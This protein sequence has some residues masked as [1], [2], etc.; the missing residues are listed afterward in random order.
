MFSTWIPIAELEAAVIIELWPLASTTTLARTSSVDAV[1]G[2][3]LHADGPLAVEQHVEHARPF[4]DLD[5]VLA[6]VVQHHLV[7]LA[8]EHLPGLRAFVR[9]V[10]VE[11][12]RLGQ[13]AA[14]R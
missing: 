3:D 8:A 14:L 2:R 6:G 12:K 7:E 10:V 11:V 4:V 9:L 13:L 5:A 1:L